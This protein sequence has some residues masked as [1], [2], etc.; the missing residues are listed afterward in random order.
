M[1]VA[2]NHGAG[3]NRYFADESLPERET[4]ALKA[5]A[6]RDPKPWVA[7]AL[8]AAVV[9][10]QKRL[11]EKGDMAYSAEA[12][13][14]LAKLRDEISTRV[15]GLSLGDARSQAVA[16]DYAKLNGEA[17]EAERRAA[18]AV[19]KDDG[20]AIKKVADDLQGIAERERKVLTA[21]ATLCPSAVVR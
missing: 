8:N 17:A 19:R 10:S 11:L 9:E 2:W 18:A 13:D 15:A 4:A 3:V 12:Y 6:R 21:L 5:F 16:A 20:A 1:S 7:L 14:S